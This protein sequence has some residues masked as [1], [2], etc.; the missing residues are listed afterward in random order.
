ERPDHQIDD[1]AA[2]IRERDERLD[3]AQRRSIR[4]A[5]RDLAAVVGQ[6]IRGARQ[7]VYV[8]HLEAD[9]LS[10]ARVLG[11]EQRVIA[12]VG[13]EGGLRIGAFDRLEAEDALREV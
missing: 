12:K 11:E 7:G 10:A 5:G 1:D 4:G 3:L 6:Q 13:A 9:R 8:A 2:R